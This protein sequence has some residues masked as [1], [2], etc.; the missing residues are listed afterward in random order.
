MRGRTGA[1]SPEAAACRDRT[2]S[3]GAATF[4]DRT[5]VS[6]PEATACRGRKV[7]AS[8]GM[9]ACRDPGG[10]G[11]AQ[12]GAGPRSVPTTIMKTTWPERA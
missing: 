9:S 7:A 4:R 1:P 8:P 5:V 11:L 10:R 2:V 3:P 6:S 12:A